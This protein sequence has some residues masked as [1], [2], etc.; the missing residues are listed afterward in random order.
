[1][2]YDLCCGFHIHSWI[3]L[4][5]FRFKFRLL[6]SKIFKI[7]EFI[8][9]ILK[10][11][12]FWLKIDSFLLKI[13]RYPM[14][15]SFQSNGHF[16]TLNLSFSNQNVPFCQFSGK[17]SKKLEIWRG[18]TVFICGKSP[19]FNFGFKSLTYRFTAFLLHIRRKPETRYHRFVRLSHA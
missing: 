7:P 12:K 18:K 10:S 4:A 14:R 8:L 1:M 5:L 17:F 6:S 15:N 9:V 3:Y 19:L 16:W 2:L 13:I 11:D